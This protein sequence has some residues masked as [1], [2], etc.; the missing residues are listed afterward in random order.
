MLTCIKNLNHWNFEKK[1]RMIVS[2]AVSGTSVFVLLIFLVAEMIFVTDRTSGTIESQTGIMA[3]NYEET[4]GQYW[5]FSVALVINDALQNYCSAPGEELAG[6]VAQ[7]VNTEFTNMLNLQNNL[8]FVAV[9]RDE[10]ERYYYKGNTSLT[11]ARFETAYQEDYENSIAMRGEAGMRLSYNDAYY[12]QG[13]YT[14]TLY[15]PVY[16]TTNLVKQMGI[17]VMNMNDSFL[18]SL[19]EKQQQ[20]MGNA[21]VLVDVDGNIC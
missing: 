19:I 10:D 21:M 17:L 11:D 18:D 20:E 12:R 8:N 15:Y 6:S 14:L 1:I 5:N 9:I 3:P 13:K 2:L 7:D 16:S 4:L